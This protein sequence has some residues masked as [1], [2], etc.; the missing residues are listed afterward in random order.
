[1]TKQLGDYFGITEGTGILINN[2]RENSPAARAGL[3]AG[4]VI[5]EIEG[6]EVKGATDLLRALNETKEGDISLT[7]IRDRNRQTVRVTPEISKNGA[8]KFEEF[9]KFSEPSSNQIQFRMQTP[10]TALFPETQIKIAP[11]IL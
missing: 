9:E 5:V 3:K 10:Q 7:I 11:R 8:M 6:K 1:L 2:V 4:D